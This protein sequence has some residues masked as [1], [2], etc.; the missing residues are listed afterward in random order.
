PPRVTRS[1]NPASSTVTPTTSCPSGRGTSSDSPADSG[2]PT[3]GT[4]Q[5]ASN[6]CPLTGRV[7]SFSPRPRAISPLPAP[8]ARPTPPARARRRTSTAL[9]AGRPPP[10]RAAGGPA[11]APGRAGPP[12]APPG[13]NP[14]PRPPPPRP[15]PP[16]VQLLVRQPLGSQ[17]RLACRRQ[18]TPQLLCP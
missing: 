16:P 3:G 6:S 9:P 7:G 14:P 8:A 10:A 11:G 15:G 18:V 2:V 13:K 4:R 5:S 1:S 17:A 12:G